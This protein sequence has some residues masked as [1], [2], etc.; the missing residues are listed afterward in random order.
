MKWY[1]KDDE[2][3]KIEIKKSFGPHD[4]TQRWDEENGRWVVSELKADA[5]IREEAMGELLRG[6]AKSDRGGQAMGL[7]L[8][9]VWAVLMGVVLGS[10]IWG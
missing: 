9:M 3:R 8:L 10:I 4:Y 5:R 2:W 6:V 7:F 1:P